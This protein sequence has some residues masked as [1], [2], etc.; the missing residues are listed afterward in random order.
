[1]YGS[2]LLL[3]VCLVLLFESGRSLAEYLDSLVD[4]FAQ[5]LAPRCVNC[6]MKKKRLDRHIKTDKTE[7]EVF[8]EYVRILFTNAAVL[9]SFLGEIDPGFV[10]CHD[11]DSLGEEA[12][13][14]K[15]AA[16]VSPNDE[17]ADMISSA[18]VDSVLEIPHGDGENDINALTFHG[19]ESLALR[20]QDKLD[21]FEA[22]YCGPK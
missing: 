9:H 14:S 4:N 13:A 18:L 16:F 3:V 21:S 15:V 7:E 17:V 1:M 8:L 19:V 12:Q 2:Q 20:L 11:W 6:R 5:H 22:L 10:V